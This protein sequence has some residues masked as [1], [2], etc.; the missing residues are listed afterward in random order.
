MV[1]REHEQL[2][3]AEAFWELARLPENQGK[4]LELDEGE[5]VEMAAS[6]PI[7]TIIAGRIIYYL[8][9]FV[10]P[11]DLGYVTV[12]D[13]GYKLAPKTVRQ[14]DAAFI[15]KARAPKIPHEF[16][17]APDL[18]VEIVSPH[19]DVWKKANEY[20]RAGTQMVWAVYPDDQMVYVFRLNSDGS[21]RGQPFDIHAALDGGEVLPGFTLAVKEIFPA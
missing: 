10:I 4:R 17:T 1:A 20:L 18:A 9:A 5:L 13:G 15:S 7:N 21:L 2:Y 8:N 3:T 11:Q 12:P 14:P 19:E 16:Q 6:K